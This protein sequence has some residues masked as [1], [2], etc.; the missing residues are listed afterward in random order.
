MI[1]IQHVSKS[2]DTLRVLDDVSLEMERGTV[3]A[4]LGPNAS[5]KST[6]IKCLLGLV[7]PDQG[8]ILIDGEPVLGRWQYRSKIGYMP[9]IARFPEN[10]TV[11]EL[12]RML[13]DLRGPGTDIDIEVFARYELGEI[14]GKRLGT[15]S[16]GTRQKILAAVAFLFGPQ[17]LVLDEPT[18]GLD[19]VSA[20]VFKDKVRK[21]RDAGRAIVLS[22]HLVNEVEEMADRI[23]YLLDGKPFFVGTTDE[24]K[25]ATSERHVDR[26]LVNLME[27][28][29]ESR[30]G[31]RR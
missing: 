27:Q 23:V 2:F 3:T 1:Q 31:T 30:H 24:L 16:G 15:L 14:G 22:S 28:A 11:D 26:A 29:Q 19:P 21:E 6:L 13:R 18:V 7:H 4:I 5:G 12:F 25:R 9:Q 10:L 17:I 20:T 8:R